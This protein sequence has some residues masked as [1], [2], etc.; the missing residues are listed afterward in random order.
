M[1]P[2]RAGKPWVSRVQLRP[3]SRVR[4]IPPVV[5][6]PVNDHGVRRRAYI[7]A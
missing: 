1:R 6:P 3:P 2:V 4:K 7:A 5:P